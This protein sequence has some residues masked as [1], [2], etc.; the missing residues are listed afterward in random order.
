VDRCLKCWEGGSLICCDFCPAAY[1]IGCLGMESEDELPKMKWSCPQHSCMHCGRKAA[2]AGGMLFRCEVC[3]D[4]YC[5]DC[6][7]ASVERNP[8]RMVGH[9]ARYQL[10][11]YDK[12]KQVHI[13]SHTI[14][15]TPPLTPSLTPSLTYHHY[16][17]LGLLYPLRRCVRCFCCECC[18]QECSR[19][20]GH[21]ARAG[22][23]IRGRHFVAV[24]GDSTGGCRPC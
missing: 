13:Y 17:P 10:L 24:V 15:H 11:G 1:H 14:P 21:R 5:E 20:D 4:A 8:E 23:Q 6:L 22:R 9:P 3:P 7:P 16:C 2:A 12:N 19:G 18:V